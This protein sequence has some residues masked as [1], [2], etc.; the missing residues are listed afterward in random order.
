MA[1]AYADVDL[2]LRE[3]WRLTIGTR[4]YLY[5]IPGRSD[6]HDLSVILRLA[7]AP[8]TPGLHVYGEM[9][10]TPEWQRAFVHLERPV[11]ARGVL[12]RPVLRIGTA[13]GVPFELGFWPGGPDGFPGLDYGE[14]RGDREVTVGLHL[15]RPLGRRFSALLSA[16]LGHSV[17]G[18][19]LFPADGWVAGARAGLGVE[20]GFGLVRVEPGITNDGRTAV[21]VRLGSWL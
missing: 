3:L 4:A 17:L 9:S 10:W 5:R 18:R 19:S 20:T 12:I 16:A 11:D 13:R 6:D 7:R 15:S 2:P 1:I 8:P 21:F 14:A